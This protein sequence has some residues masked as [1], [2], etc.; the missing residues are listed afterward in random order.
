MKLPEPGDGDGKMEESRQQFARTPFMVAFQ[1][2]WFKFSLCTVH[3]Y[4][5]SD[6]GAQLKRRIAEIERLVKFFADRQ[7]EVSRQ[8]KDD[9]ATSRIISCS[10]I[11]TSSVPSTRPCRR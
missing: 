3:I 10:A 8:E 1:S 4:Y 7:D 5:G 6:S 11:L 2:G 9:L